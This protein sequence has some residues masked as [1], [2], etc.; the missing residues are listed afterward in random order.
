MK[1]VSIRPDKIGS[2]VMGYVP[3]PRERGEMLVN[4]DLVV[5]VAPTELDEM[6]VV[7]VSLMNGTALIFESSLD[8]VRLLLMG[9]LLH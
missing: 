6:P 4:T 5:L 3:Y 7:I 1:L 9:P 8:Q 2:A